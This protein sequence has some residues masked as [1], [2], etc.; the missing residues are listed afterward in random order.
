MITAI[1]ATA[2]AITSLLTLSA[3]AFA[4]GA[5][6]GVVRG[7]D[8]KALQS[9]D[10]KLQLVGKSAGQVVK[11]DTAGRYR[12]NSVADGIYRVTVMSGNRILGFIEGVKPAAPTAKRVE[13]DIKPAAAGQPAKKAKHMVWVPAQTGSN[14][15]GRWVEDGDDAN[16]DHVEKK[17]GNAIRKYQDVAPHTTSG[18]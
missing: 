10:V 2:L 12:F 16:A 8:G 17:S 7:A 13:F 15:G 3:S 4:V 1:R 5:I 6:E 18:G 11:T 14:M 9:T